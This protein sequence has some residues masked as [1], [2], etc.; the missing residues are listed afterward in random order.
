MARDRQALESMLE[1]TAGRDRVLDLVKAISLL[2]V[3]VGHSLAWDVSGETPGNVLDSHPGLQPLTWL[4][5]VLPLFFAA[6]AV[7]NLASWGRRPDADEYRR[8][9]LIRLLTPLLVYSTVWTVI[10][11]PA[12]VAGADVVG[13]GKFL[14][15]LTWFLGVYGLVVVAVPLTSR[16]VDRP[17]PTLATWLALIL[18]IDLLR[19]RVAPA[20]GWV[21]FVLVWAWLH[22]LG[23]SLPKFRAA[24]RAAL[25]FGACAALGTALLLA[26][27][28]PYSG[29]MVSVGG[30]SE[31]SNLAPPTVVLALVGLAQVLLLAALWPALDRFTRRS[32]VWAATA[33][34]GS[35][36]IGVYL[37][38]IPIVGLVVL[39]VWLSGIALESLTPRWWVAHALGLVIVLAGAWLLAGFAGRADRRLQSWGTRRS[40]MRNVRLACFAAPVVV[41]NASVTGYASIHGAGMLGLPSSS[42]VNVALLAGCWF[43]LVGDQRPDV[44]RS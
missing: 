34:F 22:Q 6:G 12:R 18:V 4:L 15:Q 33:I 24:R 10:L 36:A 19:W 20:V 5:Q 40:A 44:D 38:H 13:A 42:L 41:L 25:L 30:D 14:S 31:L 1:L 39:A 43:V 21:N 37:W 8:H 16:W 23:Y 35:R 3:I 26:A 7:A 29:S 27:V 9:R 32:K 28:G 11:I 17:L 2:V